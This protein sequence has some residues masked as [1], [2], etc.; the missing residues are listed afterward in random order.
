MSVKP[1]SPNEVDTYT[2][3]PDEVFEAFNTLI[4]AKWD[5]R[6]AV[7][8]QSEAIDEMVKNFDGS[9]TRAQIFSNNYLNIDRFYENEG[10][11]I[12]YEKPD[13]GESGEAVFIFKKKA[14]SLIENY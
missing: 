4:L 14:K 8:R 2:N 13:M 7:I 3:Y 5:G 6:Q 10:W 12:R 9:M 11:E 1:I